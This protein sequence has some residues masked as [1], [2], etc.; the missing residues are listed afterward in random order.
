MPSNFTVNKCG[1]KTVFVRTTGHE[2]AHFTVVLSFLANGKKLNPM[3]IFK[4]KLMPKEDFPKGI[5]VHVNPKGW[6]DEEGCKIW[7]RKVW[8]QRPEGL[9]N[10]KSLLVWDMF[11]SHQVKSVKKCVYESTQI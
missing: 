2:K 6:M 11:R 10:T 8:Q 5:I 3:V 9:Q 1:E 4:R 7:L